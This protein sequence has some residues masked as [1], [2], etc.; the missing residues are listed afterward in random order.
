MRVAFTGATDGSVCFT[1]SS[2]SSAA[3]VRFGFSVQT[4]TLF[5]RQRFHSSSSSVLLS[6]VVDRSF[7]DGLHFYLVYFP[8]STDTTTVILSGVVTDRYGLSNLRMIGKGSELI[9]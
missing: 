3:V 4:C 9:S 8:G 1:V 5:D 2:V 7:M 6:R